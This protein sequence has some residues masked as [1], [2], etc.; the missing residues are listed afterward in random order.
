MDTN[1][2]IYIYITDIA[3]SNAQAYS[4]TQQEIFTTAVDQIRTQSKKP[5]QVAVDLRCKQAPEAMN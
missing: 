1:M 4:T 2:T 5:Y 3:I